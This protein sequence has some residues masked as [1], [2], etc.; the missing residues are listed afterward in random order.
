[1]TKSFDEIHDAISFHFRT[2]ADG[3]ATP[4]TSNTPGAVAASSVVG[5]TIGGQYLPWAQLR[6]AL[7]ADGGPIDDTSDWPESAK[8]EFLQVVAEHV[9]KARGRV[10]RRRMN[11]EGIGMRILSKPPNLADPLDMQAYAIELMYD[12]GDQRF[13]SALTD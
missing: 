9:A 12:A 5:A 8:T 13:I 7:V 4:P 10:E 3:L 11:I 2:A 1:M 6:H